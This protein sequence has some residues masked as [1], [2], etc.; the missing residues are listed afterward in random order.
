[1]NW[2][3][4]GL[5]AIVLAVAGCAAQPRPVVYAVPAPAPAD[6]FLQACADHAA[7]GI[8]AGGNPQFRRL[9]LETAGLY[10]APLHREVGRTYVDTVQDGYGAWYGQ[11]EWR[12]VRFHCL[13]DGAGQV[14][15]S[16]VRAE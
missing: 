16:F 11:K 3:Q 2:K 14:V 10:K 13:S 15:Y 6:G 7:A 12:R 4:T 5:M 8:R 9:R 1:M